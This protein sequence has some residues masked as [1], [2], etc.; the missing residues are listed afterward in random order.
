MGQPL[1][2]LHRGR[3]PRR[4]SLG[5]R[6]GGHG[7]REIL[8]HAHLTRFD[9][10]VGSAG[11]MRQALTLAFS[12]TQ[13]QR[14][15]GSAFAGRPMM[16]NILADLAIDAE[17]CTLLAFMEARQLMRSRGVSRR[18]PSPASPRRRRQVLE[19]QA[20]GGLMSSTGRAAAGHLSLL[21]PGKW[22]D[23][24]RRCVE[25]PSTRGQSSRR[26]AGAFAPSF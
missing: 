13:T 21:P 15:F 14:G 24:L 11:L 3:I 1:Q 23:R 9:F 22:E 4:A 8:S 25:L 12:H 18:A 26:R 16:T 7:I 19:L 5:G 10:A 20:S 2:C 6:E 17:A